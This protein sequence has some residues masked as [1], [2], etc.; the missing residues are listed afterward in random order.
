MA[1]TRFNPNQV[2]IHYS[3]RVEEIARTL[4]VRKNTVRTWL[5]SGLET[6]DHRRPAMVQGKV[7]RAFLESKRTVNR[8][9]CPPG[10]LYC[11]KCRMPRPP[12]LDMVDFVPRTSSSGN[13]RALC[14]VCGTLMHQAVNWARISDVMPNLEVRI[15]VADPRLIGSSGPS[16]KRD[17]GR[18]Q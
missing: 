11:L 2:K 7:L 3:F 17:S 13:L 18:E 16:L 12:A 1:R 14:Q 4:G 10:T 6:I 9:S 15:A 8:R 5:K